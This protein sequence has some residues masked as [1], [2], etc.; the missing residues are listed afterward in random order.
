MSVTTL[1]CI[2]IAAVTTLYISG[3][4][5]LE[6]Y[7]ALQLKQGILLTGMTGS[8]KSTCYSV[9]AKVMISL[10]N[11]HQEN[12]TED[13]GVLVHDLSLKKAHQEQKLKVTQ[14]RHENHI[15]DIN[16]EICWPH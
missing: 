1:F 16:S 15:T 2:Y 10:H 7:Y 3:F 14:L 9:L 13:E 5:I 11:H 8:G 12:S 6:L 4:Q